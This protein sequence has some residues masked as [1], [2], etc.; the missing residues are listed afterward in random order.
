MGSMP[1]VTTARS[2]TEILTVACFRG[3]SKLLYVYE[4]RIN[5]RE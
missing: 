4:T 5:K 1:T 3:E 2:E